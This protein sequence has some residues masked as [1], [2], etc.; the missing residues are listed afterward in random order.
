MAIVR[1]K[2]GENAVSEQERLE[3]EKYHTTV[4]DNDIDYSDMP[5]LTD[6]DWEKAITYAQFNRLQKSKDAG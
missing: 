5:K 4:K 1:V 3:L 2:L 6:E